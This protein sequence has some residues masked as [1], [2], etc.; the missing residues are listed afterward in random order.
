VRAFLSYSRKDEAFA[1]ELE[2]ELPAHGWD[3]WRDVQNLRAGDRW[4]VKLG[5]AIEA[6]Q[7]FVLIWSAH[8][9]Q[10]DSV[11]Q[12]WSAAVAAKRSICILTLDDKP[13]PPMLRPYQAHQ[14]VSA[15]SAAAWLSGVTLPP[16]SARKLPY[17]V[18]AVVILAIAIAT[19]VY[20]RSAQEPAMQPF[21]GFVQD[22]QG[23]PL[24]GVTVI[25]P[26]Q[27]ITVP[28]DPLGRFSFQV[29]L[30]ASTNFHL[31]IKKPGYDILTA[32]PPAGDTNFN[33]TL[34]KSA[35]S[36]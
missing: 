31:I 30:A 16:K 8:A 13:L 14:P 6:A 3:V 25:A 27:N 17:I 12:E 9:A 15:K 19:V 10:S 2:K 18:A 33:C 20:R 36:P 5:E 4:P 11:E 23:L 28:T 21:A 1:A 22:E 32:D 35:K 34:R 26:S 7:A 29:H 24:D